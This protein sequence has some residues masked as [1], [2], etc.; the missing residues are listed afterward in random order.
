MAKYAVLKQERDEAI[1]RAV[2]A[3][4]LSMKSEVDAAWAERDQAR[5]S[6]EEARGLLRIVLA[7]R[8]ELQRRLN[9]IAAICNGHDRSSEGGGAGG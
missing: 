9:S 5:L 3:E 8:Q 6:E 4:R 2:L 1:E 7:E